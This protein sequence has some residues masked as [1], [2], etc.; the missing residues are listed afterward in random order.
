MVH[1]AELQ[2]VR[3]ANERAQ[4][5]GGFLYY[6]SN[7]GPA[8][9]YSRMRRVDINSGASKYIPSSSGVRFAYI[10][11]SSDQRAFTGS[12]EYQFLDE[13]LSEGANYRY[14]LQVM[15]TAPNA[16]DTLTTEDHNIV[17]AGLK[18]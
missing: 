3:R 17:F 7:D 1:G 6:G 12:L 18:R 15:G 13:S 11:G 2:L 8:V 9:G 10:D 4:F 14:E 5:W 16:I